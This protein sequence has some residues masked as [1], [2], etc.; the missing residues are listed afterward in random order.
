MQRKQSMR[1]AVVTGAAALGMAVSSA[2]VAWALSPS[3]APPDVPTAQVSQATIQDTGS[4]TVASQESVETLDSIGTTD[5]Q[6]PA[7]TPDS[8]GTTDTQAPAESPETTGPSTSNDAVESPETTGPSTSNDAVES[9]SQTSDVEDPSYEASITAPQDEGQSDA[10]EAAALEVLATITPDQARDAALAAVPGTVGSVE[11]D[12]EN[13]AVVYSVEITDLSGSIIDVK[14]DAGN[15]T[16]LNQQASDSDSD[17]AANSDNS[18]EATD[19]SDGS[20]NDNSDN[21]EGS[22]VEDALDD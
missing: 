4:T 2:G 14:V 8:I 3:T 18:D 13:G 16:I 10:D 5:T 20:D 1:T 19:Q 15:G 9:E 22:D 17:E 21:T 12:N 7:E 11:L 6:A